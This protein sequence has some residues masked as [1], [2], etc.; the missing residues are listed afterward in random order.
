MSQTYYWMKQ[1]QIIAK[2]ALPFDV[3]VGALIVKEAD[4]LAESKL[5]SIAYN[6]RELNNKISSHAEI[7]AIEKA[8]Q[9]LNDWRLDNYTLYITLEPCLMCCGAILQ[10]RLKKI[11]F[12]AYD[13]KNGFSFSLKK[14]ADIQVIGGILEEE[15]E[16]LLSDFFQ[17][18]RQ[19]NL[20]CKDKKH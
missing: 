7:I 2:Q 20:Q 8:A 13:K 15:C 16:L 11:I 19:K 12:G 3:P 9:K 1:A 17:S 14:Y 4:N 6:Q 5:I 18:L 10:S